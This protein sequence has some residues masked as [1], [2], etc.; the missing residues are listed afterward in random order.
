M[1]QFFR[2]NDQGLKS[3]LGFMAL[4]GAFGLAACQPLSNPLDAPVD[5]APVSA[6]IEVDPA[7]TLRP[8]IPSGLFG[9]NIE[10]I[11]N[12]NGLA[13]DQGMVA[14]AWTTRVA[15]G[16]VDHLRWPGGIFSDYY[17]WKDGIGPVTSRP[18]VPHH[19]DAGNGRDVLGTPGIVRWA[20]ALG[21]GLLF[22]VNAGSGTASEAADWVRYCNAPGD[23]RRAADGST[24]PLGI[25][26]WEVGN[27]LYLPE[28]PG[29]PKVAINAATYAARFLEFAAAMRAAAPSTAIR[30]HAIGGAT[31]S[32][33]PPPDPAW[34]DTLLASAG[35][36]VDVL[37]VHNAYH[38]YLYN[39]R[40]AS[41]TTR[42]V[43]QALWASPE[44]IGASLDRLAG[45]LSATESARGL[46]SGK[47]G[48]S[49]TEWGPLFGA[50]PKWVD[51]AK[52]LGSA[53]FVA[54][55]FQILFAR[56]RVRFAEAFKLTDSFTQGWI[57]WDGNPK[58]IWRVFS[59][60]ARQKNDRLV[61]SRVYGSKD[62]STERLGAVET[63][64]G[65]E[66]LCAQASVSADGRKLRLSA[67]NRSWNRP[68]DVDLSL[69]APWNTARGTA[70]VLS[71]ASATDHDGPDVRPWIPLSAYSEV[72]RN[73]ATS[74]TSST[75]EAGKPL[76][77]PPR[78]VAMLEWAL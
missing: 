13:D 30:L 45:K 66:E 4:L 78:S 32:W 7:S 20:R 54:R 48:L 44:A 2:S 75:L 27:E 3:R 38:P 33:A 49:I 31:S 72:P 62:F 26:D 55:V 21:A 69:P 67:V 6:S 58:P 57:G 40:E 1:I 73:G 18:T 11:E 28:N 50:D 70:Q 47:I 46:A 10:W 74:L 15:A 22:T 37:A 36:E 23:S 14:E 52:T 60:F 12:G 64:T 59:L 16:G 24:A 8:T 9:F 29:S 39:A 43:Y 53:V 41:R 61:A 51:H 42:E 17:H 34:I 63:A 19:T 5:L 35:A 65:L 25:V 71:G 76:K 68:Y 56:E 77:L